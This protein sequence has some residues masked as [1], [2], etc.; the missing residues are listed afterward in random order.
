MSSHQSFV[1]VEDSNQK[2]D[3]CPK[4]FKL[5]KSQVPK[6]LSDAQQAE[7]WAVTQTQQAFST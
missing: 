2:M 1:W 6:T 4:I 5:L 3:R 7:V